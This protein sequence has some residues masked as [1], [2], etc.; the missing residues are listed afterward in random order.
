MVRQGAPKYS[1]KLLEDGSGGTYLLHS[2]RNMNLAVFKPMA[3]EPGAPCNP[4]PT[5]K[6]RTPRRDGFV[7][8]EGALKE[9]LAFLI[10]KEHFAGVPPTVLME[11]GWPGKPR[12]LGSVQQFVEHG[13]MCAWD[14]GPQGFSADEVHAIA[15]LDLRLCNTDRHGGNILLAPASYSPTASLRAIRRGEAYQNDEEAGEN[16]DEDESEG[17]SEDEYAGAE[18]DDSP[19]QFRRQVR[20]VPIDHGYCLPSYPHLGELW[21]EWMTWPQCRKPLSTRAQHYI[22]SLDERADAELALAMGLL[23][24][25]SAVTLCIGTMLVKHGAAAG[26]TIQEMASIAC[27]M[28]GP[29]LPS[30]L[31]AMCAAADGGAVLASASRKASKDECGVRHA[32]N[33]EEVDYQC[34]L[35]LEAFGLPRPAA[36]A[37][38]DGASPLQRWQG[39]FNKLGVLLDA[40]IQTVLANRGRRRPLSSTSGTTVA[41]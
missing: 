28:D 4:R 17:E 3:E 34:A 27:R 29:D 35:L 14:V 26:L 31:E 12:Q 8:G 22:A 20:L 19:R 24:E 23:N 25:G 38:P 33:Q 7:P 5:A 32:V 40:H 1:P 41:L 18:D 13:G 30:A 9:V 6:V 21:F 39:F 37:E 36:Y 2:A 11:M 16:E 10:D 15:L